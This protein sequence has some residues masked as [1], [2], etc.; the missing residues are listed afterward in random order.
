[1]ICDL[2]SASSPPYYRL[3]ASPPTSPIIYMSNPVRTFLQSCRSHDTPLSTNVGHIWFRPS[4]RSRRRTHRVLRGK[5]ITRSTH[6]KLVSDQSTT[7]NVQTT[8][9]RIRVLA[10][11]G[12]SSKCVSGTS[13]IV[14]I[15]LL[16]LHNSPNSA[17][18]RLVYFCERA[19]LPNLL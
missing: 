6:K 2:L 7:Y 9:I 3:F 5:L 16:Q 17:R 11:V 10:S 18:F 8:M 19:N 12:C 13:R 15:M 14:T 4:R 1:M